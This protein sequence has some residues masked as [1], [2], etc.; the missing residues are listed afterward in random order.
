MTVV[1]IGAGAG[2]SGDRLD[3]AVDLATRGNLDYLV[4][5]CLAERTI[6]L[7]HARKSSGG[8]GYDPLLEERLEAVLP[9]CHKAGTTII[10]NMGAA[11]P[12]AAA[13]QASRVARRLGLSPVRIAALVGDDITLRWSKLQSYPS[14]PPE[15]LDKLFRLQTDIVA[16]NVYLGAAHLLPALSIGAQVV[17]TGRV[18]DPS[19]F[20]AP[21]MLRFGWSEA[22]WDF[23]GSGTLVGHLLECAGQVTGGYFADPGLKNVPDLAHLGF[24][25]AE[26]EPTGEAVITKLPGTG[27]LINAATLTEQILYELHDPASYVT[28]DCVADFSAVELEPLGPDKVRVMGARGRERTPFLKAAVAYRDGYLGEGLISYAGTGAVERAELAAAIIEERLKLTGISFRDLRFDLI[29][30]NSLHGRSPRKHSPPYEVRLRVAGKANSFAEAAII[31]R[32]VE[33][34]YTNGPAGGG[35]VSTSMREVIAIE[36]VL[37]PREFVSPQVI[38]LEV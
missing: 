18:A 32:E 30:L 31:G 27:G 2:F 6:A 7:A 9:P 8:P 33:A 17:I 20:L 35:G 10:T 15:T 34:L 5:E 14:T 24:P 3:P 13:I 36:D 16:V 29:G 12:E 26:V 22:A 25:L 28:P 37:I 11:D 38:C 19:L 21:L 23:L 1:R 4:F